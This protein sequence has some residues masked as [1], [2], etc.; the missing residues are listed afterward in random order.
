MAPKR[1]EVMIEGADIMFRNFGGAERQFNAEGDRNFCVMLDKHPEALEHMERNGW[2]I[3]TL[4][5]REEGDEPRPYV[6]VKVEYRKGRPP[7]CILVS[8]RKRPDL[9]ADEVGLLD[10]AEFQNVDV[11]LTGYHWEIKR[12]DDT[13]TGVKAYLKTGYFT[14]VQDPLVEKYEDKIESEKLEEVTT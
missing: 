9:G 14:I 13:Q 2:N 4:K 5:A 10:V 12:G 3:K 6:Q 7:R 8:G 11:L 1:D